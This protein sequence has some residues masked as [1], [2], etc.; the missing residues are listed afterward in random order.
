MDLSKLTPATWPAD[1]RQ[2][3]YRCGVAGIALL[4]AYKLLPTEHAP[5]WL[6][7]LANIL[8]VGGATA[9]TVTADRTLRQQRADG[10][11]E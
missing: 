5:L 4:V 6:D 11:L 7:L 9:A 3:V 8:G 10:V 2:W 1:R